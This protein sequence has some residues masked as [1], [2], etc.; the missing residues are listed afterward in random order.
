MKIDKLALVA[1]A[2][3]LPVLAAQNLLREKISFDVFI[4]DETGEVND[5]QE[6]SFN[7]GEI[8]R[9]PLS[10]TQFGKFLKI[11]Q[12][13]KFSHVLF[14]GKVHKNVI[15]STLKFD[16]KSLMLMR[17]M[18]NMNDDNILNVIEKEFKKIDIT[19]IKQT[20]FLTYLLLPQGVFSKK[21][22]SKKDLED[23]QYGFYYAKKL[24]QMDVG[25]TVIVKNKT[26]LALEAIEGTDACIERGGQLAKKHGAIVCKAEKTKQDK[27]W[28]I[29]TIGI[30]TLKVM[31]KFGC[32]LLAIEANTTFVVT[33]KEVI[34]AANKLGIILVS[35]VVNKSYKP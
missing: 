34:T 17:A 13:E 24:G 9:R 32:T 4:L 22:P 16:F 35:V 2:G 31:K 10:L 14:L 15:F 7:D 27:R 30:D 23:V 33:P 26:V 20:L 5:N 11:L 3:Q 1:G 6:I 21:K 12:K 18:L 25:Q 8:S 28:D 29:P 19:I